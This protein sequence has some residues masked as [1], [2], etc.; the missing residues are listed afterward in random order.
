MSDHIEID[1]FLGES[2][3]YSPRGYLVNSANGWITPNELAIGMNGDFLIW[4]A[5]QCVGLRWPWGGTVTT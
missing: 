4:P 3:W 5:L 2:F 1:W